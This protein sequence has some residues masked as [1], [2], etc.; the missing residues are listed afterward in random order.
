MSE[1]NKNSVREGKDLEGSAS[2]LRASEAADLVSGLR[3]TSKEYMTDCDPDD[4]GFIPFTITYSGNENDDQPWEI[5][6]ELEC[7][8]H[9]TLD[10]LLFWNLVMGGPFISENLRQKINH[11]W[12]TIQATA[13][14]RERSDRGA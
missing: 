8:T 2:E 4:L 1:A 3:S 5:N 7:D 10:E 12:E 13:R 11:E 6:S 9:H 14:K